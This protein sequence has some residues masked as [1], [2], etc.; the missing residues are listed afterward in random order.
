MR[1]HIPEDIITQNNPLNSVDRPSGLYGTHQ[2]VIADRTAY[3]VPLD[4]LYKYVNE[5]GALFTARNIPNWQFVDHICQRYSI[6][7]LIVNDADP[8]WDSLLKLKI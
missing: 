1:D 7:L 4:A 3:G 6:D 8:I 2:M 5:I